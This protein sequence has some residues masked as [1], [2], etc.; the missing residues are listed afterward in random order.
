MPINLIACVVFHKNKFAIGNDNDLLCK[1]SDDLKNFKSKTIN[2]VVVMGRNTY[3]SLPPNNRPL[4]SRLNIVLTKRKTFK[5]RI[6]N[7]RNTISNVKYMNLKEF[8]VYYENELTSKEVFIIG[9][10][11]IYDIFLNHENLQPSKLFLTEVY[12]KLNFEPNKFMQIPKSNYYL[13]KF[14][15]LKYEN[16]IKYRFLEYKNINTNTNSSCND[17]PLFDNNSY[18]FEENYQNLCKNVLSNGNDRSDRTNVG[19]L[20]LFG[21]QIEMDISEFVPLLT[22]KRVA[23]KSCIEELLW[24]LRGDTDSNI[25]KEKGI[26]IWNGNSSREFLDSKGLTNYREGVIGPCFPKGTKLLTFDNSYINIENVSK[27]DLVLGHSGNWRNINKI[28]K[29]PY[30]GKLIKINNETICTPEHPFYVLRPSKKQGLKYKLYSYFFNKKKYRNKDNSTKKWVE[31]EYLTK[32]DM[33]CMKINTNKTIPIFNNYYIDNEDIWFII[34][35]F[36][37]GGVIYKNKI[38]FLIKKNEYT[39]LLHNP[40][41]KDYSIISEYKNL[42]LLSYKNTN[43]ILLDLLYQ[44]TNEMIPEWVQDAP[45]KYIKEFL[46]GYSILPDNKMTYEL[47]LSLQRLNLKVGNYCTIY[48]TSKMSE[49]KTHLYK[50]KY[51]DYDNC[52]IDD[53]GY[54]WFKIF[55]LTHK[56]TKNVCDVYNLEV[57]EDNTYTINNSLVHNCYGWQWRFYNAEYNQ[58]YS[59][60]NKIEDRTKIGGIDQIETII[61]EIKTNPYSRR[62]L[63]NAWNPSMLSEMAL[64]PCHFGFQFYVREDPKCNYKKYLDCHFM[65]RSNDLGCG[66]PFNYFSYAVLTYI[67]AMKVNM[68]PGKLVYTVSDA[69]IYKNHITQINELIERQP[70]VKPVLILDESIKDKSFDDITIDDFELIG[71]YPYPSI[72]M[73]M[74]I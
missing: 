8:E 12:T 6:H 14:S 4:K 26:K 49:N 68:S 33:L 22:T 73:E 44:F 3:N 57:D 36:M 23:W 69:H 24:F 42:M 19:T 67:I 63:I 18:F 10:G 34:G 11:E 25:L 48:K 74:A 52:I 27:D 17:V 29:R 51:N 2:N 28:M 45:D 71:Y 31:A 9:G 38:M 5:E 65:M 43:K 72:K 40:N 39:C 20:S 50:L 56:Y 53:S 15:E 58:D 61:N 59:D 32:D 1:I 55:S 37:K 54:A 30:Y 35:L 64:P 46:Y 62:L 41:I 70:R 21:K 47:A 66:A 7:Y 16:N 60:T 13:T